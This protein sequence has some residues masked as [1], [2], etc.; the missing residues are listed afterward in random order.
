MFFLHYVGTLE[1]VVFFLIIFIM[2]LYLV[3]NLQNIIAVIWWRTSS[4][5]LF[6]KSIFSLSCVILYATIFLDVFHM[7][8]LFHDLH[9]TVTTCNIQP[10]RSIL[11][12]VG[13][14]C[15]YLEFLRFEI[16]FKTVVWNNLVLNQGIYAPIHSCYIRIFLKVWMNLERHL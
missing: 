13:K 3:G 12:I 16:L 5:I 4:F 6:F 14:N 15:A 11:H 8:R 10:S 1:Y 2:K 9:K 7:L